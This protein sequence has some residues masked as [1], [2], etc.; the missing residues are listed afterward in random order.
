MRRWVVSIVVDQVLTGLGKPQGKVSII[1][2]N[3]HILIAHLE[4]T[5]GNLLPLIQVGR[6]GIPPPALLAFLLVS[7]GLVTTRRH[8]L[9]VEDCVGVDNAG[10]GCYY[11]TYARGDQE[12]LRLRDPSVEHDEKEANEDACLRDEE[13]DVLALVVH[14][15]QLVVVK[16]TEHW[17]E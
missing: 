1:K 17:E 15:A 2:V 4:L 16:H 11:Q 13:E 10:N 3:L 8:A 5:D 9:H 6:V 14:Q 12:I 7:V